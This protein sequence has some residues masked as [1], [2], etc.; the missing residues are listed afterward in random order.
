MIHTNNLKLNFLYQ[1]QVHKE[2]IINENLM[3]TDAMISND[4][5]SMKSNELP[6]DASIGDKYILVTEGKLAVKLEDIWHYITVRD[7]MIFWII[8]E[9]KL[10]VH[11][12]GNWKTLFS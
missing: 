11:S 7:G 5:K 12:R 6:S 2:I 9:E 8:D 1:N 3:I 10:V 4:V